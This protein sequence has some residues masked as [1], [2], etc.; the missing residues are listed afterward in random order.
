MK[1]KK[2][3]YCGKRIS[4]VSVYASRRKSEYV[5]GRC[6]KESKVIINK[7]VILIFVVTALIALAIMALWIFLGL[8]NNPLGI[9]LVA[10]P[11]I[12]FTLLTPKFVYFE[13]LKKYK[14]SME[15][16]KAGIE[17][18]DNLITSEL[19]DSNTYSFSPVS[20]SPA[21]SVSSDTG[22]DF[23]INSDV[24]NKIRAERTAARKKLDG[25]DIISD[26]ASMG[27]VKKDGYVPVKGDISENHVSTDVPLKKIHSE[28]VHSTVR[29]NHHYISSEAESESRNVQPKRPDGNRYSS[30]RKF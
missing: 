11:F 22:S 1:I 20:S 26:S 8:L 21:S 25:N 6:S 23:H 9:L 28:N 24:F 12:I 30:N 7:S 4:Y 29:R 14:K 13:P 27:S 15:A 18:S 10:L 3:P 16:K 19:D 2:C 5:C 17:Y